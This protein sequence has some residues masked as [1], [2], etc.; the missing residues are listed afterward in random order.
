MEI[1][2]EIA[3]GVVGP[4]DIESPFAV[5]RQVYR[6]PA[7]KKLAMGSKLKTHLGG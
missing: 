2:V 7:L 1:L 6:R 4:E 3:L 5:G